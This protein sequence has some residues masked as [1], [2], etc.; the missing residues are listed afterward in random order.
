MPE[1]AHD[2]A[3]PT[4]C[5]ALARLYI[6]HY[7][8]LVRLAALLTGDPGSADD[9]AVDSFVA[10]CSAGLAE[11]G[12]RAVSYLRRQVVMR[13]RQAAGGSRTAACEQP[14]AGEAAPGHADC[15]GDP[16]CQLA[17]GRFAALPVVVGLLT[18]RPAEREAI[19]LTRYLDLP[20]R[21]AAA[22]AGVSQAALRRDLASA[23]KLL[24]AQL[25]G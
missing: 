21:Q 15:P 20:E 7:R 12:D 1:T 13:S 24:G 17:A 5:Q 23:I 11:A 4:A 9:L 25:A 22:A 18:L 3:E 14:S 10:L 6:N 19:V 16:G 2:D 8:S